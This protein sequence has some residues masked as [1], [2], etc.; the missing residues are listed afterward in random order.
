MLNYCGM[1]LESIVPFTIMLTKINNRFAEE[2]LYC[3]WTADVPNN[4]EIIKLNYT[5]L[6][7]SATEYLTL[8]IVYTNGK[9][10]SETMIPQQYIIAA[11]ELSK[12][13]VY[14]TTTASEVNLPFVIDFEIGDIIINNYFGLFVALGVV[15]FFCIV[16]TIFFYKCSKIIIENNRRWNE[17]RILDS[18]ALQN[19]NVE[20]N[21]DEEI[22]RENKEMLEKYFLTD[23]RPRKYDRKLNEYGSHCTICQEDFKPNQLDVIKLF[24]KHIFHYKCLKDWLDLILLAPKCPNCNDQILGKA[25]ERSELDIQIDSP[26]RNRSYSPSRDVLFLGDNRRGNRS[27]INLQRANNDTSINQNRNGFT[28]NF[29]ENNLDRL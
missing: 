9:T 21:R 7:N 11:S 17:R 14:F 10:F 27:V 12:I 19:N 18:A 24:C 29:I 22:K 25:M 23:L 16:C 13:N 15:G 1:I 8:E 3:R 4:T 6:L 20:V 26:E 5:R 2:N 28:N